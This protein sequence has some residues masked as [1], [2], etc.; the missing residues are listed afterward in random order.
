MSLFISHALAEGAETQSTVQ[1]QSP[2]QEWFQSAFKKFGEMPLWGWAVVA[3]LLLLGLV[4]VF[5]GRGN[6]EK[7]GWSIQKMSM[8]AICM[9]LT[10]VLSMIRII[11]M[12]MGGSINPAAHLPLLLFAYVYGA[13]SGITLGALYG[14]FNFILDGGQFAWAGLIPNL[15]DYPIGFALLGLAGL[16][17]E[18]G[19]TSGKEY[20]WLNIAIIVGSFGRFFAAFLSG[21]IF[22]GEYCTYYGFNSP[23]L[24]SICYNGAYML[25]NCI[26]CCLLGSIVGPRL[27]KIL[28]SEE[29][30][31]KIRA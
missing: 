27:V 6:R 22:Y 26:I 5:S 15:L 1:A 29:Q 17:G 18:K 3:I 12:P 8:G 11:R 16:F 19:R 23:I 30:K 13:P 14:I 20:L 7:R 31:K 4:F 21:W 25:P 24:Y 2:V 10:V 9:S 28:R